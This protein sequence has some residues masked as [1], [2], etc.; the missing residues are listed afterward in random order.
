M[1]KQKRT[2]AQ[3][4][5]IGGKYKGRKLR[6]H[7]T[8]GLRPTLGRSRETLFNWLRPEIDGL[9]CLDLFAGTGILGL[10]ALSQG[11]CRATLVEQNRRSHDQIKDNIERLDCA[12]HTN[13]VYGDGIK[14]LASSEQLFDL[15]FLDPPFDQPQLYP[16][17][18][19]LVVS[20]QKQIRFIYLETNQLQQMQT[21]LDEYDLRVDRHARSGDAHS[22]LAIPAGESDP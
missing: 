20:Q 6:F 7:T 5:I 13:L 18:L 21:W 15:I 8:N 14:Y 11:A 4:R 10:E 19:E 16:Q 9:N 3:V 2:P 22:I 12:R 1:A 17:A